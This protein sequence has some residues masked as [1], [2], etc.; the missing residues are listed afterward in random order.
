MDVNSADGW[1]G[2]RHG[3]GLGR[4]QVQGEVVGIAL[5][6][7]FHAQ[8]GAIHHVS[9]GVHHPALTIQDGLVEVEAVE[10]EGHGGHPHGGEPDAD[11]RPGRQEEVEA[12]AVVEGGVLEDETT[13]VAV[14]G[15]DV[16]GLFLLAKLVAVVLG[17]A[18]GGFPHQGRGDQGA[19]HGGEERAT[20]NTRH[21]QHVEGVHEDVVLRLE[22]QHEV[23]GAG[24]T[25]GHAVGEGA[26]TKGVDQ[27]HGGSSSHRGAIGHADPGAHPQPVGQFPLAAHVGGNTNEE[28]EHHQLVRTAVV[29][30]LIQGGCFPDGIEVQADG[31]G[32]GDNSTGDDVVAVHQGTGDGLTDAVNVHRRGGNEGDD[33]AGGGSEQGGDHQH[34]EPTHIE[35]VVGAGHPVAEG[36][37]SRSALALPKCGGHQDRWLGG[38]QGGISAPQSVT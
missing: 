3:G 5:V 20:E 36:L 30:P 11:H 8:A 34:T 35:A 15:H 6:H 28:V 21:P 37:P 14:G 33:E 31:V 17:L 4:S 25:Q 27:E 38:K 24:D 19:V 26:L 29:E 13:K 10:V 16:I 2:E 12:T 32:G 18:L 1:S 22:H 23:E 7:H 9:P